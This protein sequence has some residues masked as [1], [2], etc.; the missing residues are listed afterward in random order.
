MITLEGPQPAT[1]AT[2]SLD[3][4]HY[5]DRQIRPIAEPVLE[6]LGLDFRKVVGDDRQLELF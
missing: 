5:V 1:A 6:I 4:E 2:V 3:H